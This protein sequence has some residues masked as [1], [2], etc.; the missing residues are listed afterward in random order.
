MGVMG[1][2]IFSA[3][4]WCPPVDYADPGGQPANFELRPGGGL[5]GECSGG[6]RFAHARCD[7]PCCD[8]YDRICDNCDGTG[9]E[10]DFSDLPALTLD[11]LLAPLDPPEIR[12]KRGGWNVTT[13]TTPIYWL[14]A[15]RRLSRRTG[16]P[17]RSCHIALEQTFGDFARAAELLVRGARLTDGV[18][19][20]SR[21]EIQ[22][23][24]TFICDRCRDGQHDGCRGGTWC[25][26]AHKP[27][28]AR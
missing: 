26:C 7:C 2:E 8:P 19:S 24:P 10:P 13:A 27:T 20:Q 18:P 25:D 16:F 11:Q 21:S 5:C 23:P 14:Q 1:G 3:S 9:V 12:T 28:P 4:G 22:A 6:G 17:Q 15:S